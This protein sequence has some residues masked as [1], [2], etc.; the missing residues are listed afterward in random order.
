M[1]SQIKIEKDGL[2]CRADPDLVEPVTEILKY[3]RRVRRVTQFG[4]RIEWK[5]AYFIDRRNGRFLSGLLDRVTTQ[6]KAKGI[7]HDVV[8]PDCL[9]SFLD[10]ASKPELDGLTLRPDQLN[11][12]SQARRFSRGVIVSP[13]GSGKTITAL[14]IISQWPG[15]RSLILVHRRDIVKQFVARARAHLPHTEV[16]EIKGTDAF[17]KGGIVC[18]TIQ[19]MS[20][21]PLKETIDLFDI[22]ICDEC[23]H[24]SNRQGMYGRFLNSNLAPVKI[25]FTATLPTDRATMLSME[26]ILGPV[27]GE[28]TLKESQDKGIIV[29]PYVTLVPVPYDLEI[30]DLKKYRDIYSEG[31]VRNRAR[32]ARI[33]KLA[34][35]RANR[36][37]TSII[38]ITEVKHGDNLIKLA[39]NIGL[40]AE[41]V[42]GA[43]KSKDRDKIK[44]LLDSKKVDSVICTNV[45]KEGIDIPT[46]GAIFLAGGGKSALSVLQG[47]GRGLRTSEGKTT[48]EIVDFLDPYR[49]LAEHAIARMTVY[50]EKGWFK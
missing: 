37:L 10:Y 18:S 21:Y 47:V 30:G 17:L 50:A 20:R 34:A 12:I 42:Q 16:Q 26:A 28:L 41:F 49:Y 29:K 44:E 46:V 31:I 4:N 43:T 32:N 48:A 19:S 39:D 14:G 27:I 9:E 23:H 33:I 11:L 13:T 3:K 2:Y 5:E 24:V 36:N 25:G 45:W 7:D 8:T 40:D 22:V 6:L 1:K 35:E 15:A 38:L